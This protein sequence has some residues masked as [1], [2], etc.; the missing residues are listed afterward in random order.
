M[1]SGL[2]GLSE[3]RN[4][5]SLGINEEASPQR[6]LQSSRECAVLVQVG[7]GIIACL[8]CAGRQGPEVD[9]ESSQEGSCLL[10]I[11]CTGMFYSI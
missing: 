9:S 3:L 8:R 10:I 5:L 4:K 2:P 1:S 11:A 6:R 7:C